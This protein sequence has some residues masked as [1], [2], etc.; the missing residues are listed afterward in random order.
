MGL[1]VTELVGETRPGAQP[2]KLSMWSIR[3]SLVGC[4]GRSSTA[5]DF[6]AT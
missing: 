3:F 5:S 1:G 4:P 6:C 2:G